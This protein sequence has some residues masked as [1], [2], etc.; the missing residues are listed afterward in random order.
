MRKLSIFTFLFLAPAV[1]V[2]AA[3][4]RGAPQPASSNSPSAICVNLAADYVGAS[5]SLSYNMAV[6]LVDNSAPR[7][8]LRET[9]NS[10][11]LAQARL[12]LDLMMANSCRLPTSAPSPKYLTSALQCRHDE[13]KAEVERS[14]ITPASCDRTQWKPDGQTGN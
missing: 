6:G 9:Q 12:T 3:P 14:T 11:I 8:T 10:N 13:I 4:P 7:A 2:L 5:K 1:G